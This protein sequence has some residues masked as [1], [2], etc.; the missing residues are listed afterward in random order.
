ME[1]RRSQGAEWMDEV[2]QFSISESEPTKPTNKVEVVQEESTF[3]GLRPEIIQTPVYDEVEH[4]TEA[5]AAPPP[6]R[7]RPPRPLSIP[8][9]PSRYDQVRAPLLTSVQPNEN[10]EAKPV[11]PS[12]MSLRTFMRKVFRRDQKKAS[13]L[14]NTTCHIILSTTVFVATSIL[15]IPFLS[16]LT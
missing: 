12:M 15:C 2:R 16:K 1:R 11:A 8:T 10:D 5:I 7:T 6:A 3:P 9:L 13:Q 14:E 4:M